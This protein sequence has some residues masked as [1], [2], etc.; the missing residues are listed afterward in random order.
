MI[1]TPIIATIS[2]ILGARYTHSDLEILF[3]TNEA[4]EEVPG[5]NKVDKCFSWLK[6]CNSATS[7]SPFKVVGSILKNFME[8]DRPY[9]SEQSAD[10]QEI[11]DKLAQHGLS[12]Q[13]GGLIL[14]ASTGIPIRTLHDILKNK[15]L[16]GV[17]QEFQRALT[18][19][20]SDPPAGLT[21]ASSIIESLCKIYIG[22][23]GLKLPTVLTIKPLWEVVSKDLGLD[24]K[25]LIDNDLK[26][27]LSGLTSIID[28]LGSIRTHGGSA[29]GKGR[30]PYSIEARH[31][32]LAVHSAH[33]LCVFIIETWQKRG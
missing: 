25:L 18:T 29:H 24:P 14:N 13:Q 20:E 21:A 31:A 22:D 7:P 5:G 4:P 28:G 10:R 33:T 1:P 19:I 9:D 23:K 16:P 15:D 26:K 27:I 17:E 30:K 11:N 3:L 32:R 6:A 12:Y 2:K 8:I